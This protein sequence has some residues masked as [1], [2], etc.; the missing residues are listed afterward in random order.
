M[1]FDFFSYSTEFTA[2]FFQG[3]VM[4]QIKRRNPAKSSIKS[5]VNKICKN[6]KQTFLPLSAVLKVFSF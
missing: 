1:L 4:Q 6:V 3:D 5:D 2:E